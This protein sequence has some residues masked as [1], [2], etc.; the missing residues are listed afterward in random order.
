VNVTISTIE[1]E[2]ERVRERATP[3][4]DDGTV[5]G[6]DWVIAELAAIDALAGRMVLALWHAD[7]AR[8]EAK[9]Q[10]AKAT[11]RATLSAEGRTVAA[12]AAEVILAVEEEQAAADVAEAA[13]GYARATAALVDDRRSS[14][15]S[16]GKQ[17]E[18]TYQLAGTGRSGR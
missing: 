9:A 12:R 7:T 6:P 18:I 10:L 16:T 4:P 2:V 8:R 3:L 17:V 14:I 11:A 13:Y 5:R 1:D 15:Q